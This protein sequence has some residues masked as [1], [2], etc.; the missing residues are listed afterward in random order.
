MT[1]RYRQ[2]L[3]IVKKHSN[4]FKKFEFESEINSIQNTSTGNFSA[5][6]EEPSD[7]TLQEQNKLYSVLINYGVPAAD[8]DDLKEDYD[9]LRV[10]IQKYSHGEESIPILGN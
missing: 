4:N 2:L 3:L 9:V 5:N 8:Y 10:I 6:N 1:D 7:L